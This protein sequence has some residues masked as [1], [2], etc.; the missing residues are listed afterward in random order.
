MTTHR[1]FNIALVA[2]I[3]ATMAGIQLLDASDLEQEIATEQR[4]YMHAVTVCHRMHGPQTQPEYNERGVVVCVGA[5]GQVY[6]V[7]TK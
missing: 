2:A 6:Q 7:A 5:R 1:F 4:E 3:L